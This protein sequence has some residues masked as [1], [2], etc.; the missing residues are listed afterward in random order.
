MGRLQELDARLFTRIASA[1]LRGAD[2]VLPRLG[3]AADHGLLWMAAATAMGLSRD[4]SARRAALRGI[5]S[6]ALSSAAANLVAKQLL[7]RRRPDTRAVPLSRRLLRAP[8]TTSFPS[9]HAASAAAFATAATLESPR[10][11]AA[12]VPLAAAVAA[13]RVYTG[14]HYPGDVLAG[15][16]LGAGIAAATLRWW[17]LR[18]DGTAHTAAPRSALPAL[19][20]GQGLIVLVNSASGTARSAASTVRDAL[21]LADVRTCEPG[22]DLA[23]LLARAATEA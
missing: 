9:G 7:V 5:G 8:V 14:A 10:L 22:Q 3:R 4:R 20:L 15:A 19:P 17:P 6:L 23:P 16:A 12:L 13:S 11:G 1:R 18:T 21:P 2:P